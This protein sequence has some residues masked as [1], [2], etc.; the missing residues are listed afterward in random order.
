[1]Y[2]FLDCGVHSVGVGATEVGVGNAREPCLVG[3]AALV[4][5]AWSDM[6]RL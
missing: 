4:W 6:D 5:S 1:L 3:K 2:G